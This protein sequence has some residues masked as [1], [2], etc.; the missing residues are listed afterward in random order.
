MLKL[1]KLVE[2]HNTKTVLLIFT[3][4]FREMIETIMAQSKTPSYEHEFKEDASITD[5]NK[6]KRYRQEDERLF[7]GFLFAFW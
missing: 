7:W 6:L 4:P 2:I 3:A 5:F 1:R